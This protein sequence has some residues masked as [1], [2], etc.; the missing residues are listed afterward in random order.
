[1]LVEAKPLPG[2]QFKYW[3]DNGVASVFQPSYSFISNKDR[4]LTAHFTKS[5]AEIKEANWSFKISPNPAS[6]FIHIEMNKSNAKYTVSLSTLDGKL[7][8]NY[9]NPTR[10]AVEG[11]PRGIYL[12]ELESDVVKRTE[13]LILR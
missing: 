3:V 13:K 6:D 11:L 9:I 7:V 10:I 4:I 8:G 2:Y 1:M 5:T 12:I